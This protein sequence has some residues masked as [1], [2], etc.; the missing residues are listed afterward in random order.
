MTED[1]INQLVSLVSLHMQGTYSS[2]LGSSPWAYD[3]SDK[4]GQGYAWALRRAL[5]DMKLT[6]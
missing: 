4:L 5:R 2:T 6:T 3:I 1:E